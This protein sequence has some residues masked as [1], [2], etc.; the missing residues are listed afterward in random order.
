MDMIVNL[1]DE[2]GA[3]V[4]SIE[5][6]R[7]R[8][9]LRDK[10]KTCPHN[11]VEADPSFADLTCKACE[12]RINPIEWLV[13]LADKWAHVQR[14]YRRLREQAGRLEFRKRAKCRHCGKFTDLDF[15]D[16]DEKRRQRE[17]VARYRAALDRIAIFVEGPA[18]NAGRIAREALAFMPSPTAEGVP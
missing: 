6:L 9:I 13:G 7:E 18:G 12:R 10:K 5:V 8:R 4:V 15:R 2:A 1:V 11:E 17:E 16:E 14:L 3:A